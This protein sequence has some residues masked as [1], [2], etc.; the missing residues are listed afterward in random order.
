MTFKLKAWQIYLICVVI[1]SFPV[2]IVLGNFGYGTG[3]GLD[4]DMGSMTFTTATIGG[5]IL[6]VYYGYKREKRKKQGSK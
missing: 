6:A 1:L 4:Y 5:A 3:E 2:V